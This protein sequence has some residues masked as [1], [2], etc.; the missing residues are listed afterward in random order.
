MERS[1]ELEQLSWEDVERYLEHDNRLVFVLGSTEQHGDLSL[2]TDTLNALEIARRATRA[3]GVLLAQALSYGHAG[4]H[5]A[6]PGTLYVSAEAY[7]TMVISLARSAYDA[8]FRRLCFFNGHGPNSFVVAYLHELVASLDDF[9]C[10]FYEWL[11]EPRVRE[12]AMEIRS[13]GV[14]HANWAENWPV[15][16][17][18]DRSMPI[19]APWWNPEDNVRLLPPA[20]IRRIAPSGVF[21]GPTQIPDDELAPLIELAVDLGRARLR[22]LNA[23]GGPR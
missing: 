2:A 8:G 10:D 6:W 21:G 12:L 11:A 22:R 4:V 3:E 19:D 23:S 18:A 9:V 16:R 17:L 15:S 14:A 1:N 5:R 20:E 13:P 7:S